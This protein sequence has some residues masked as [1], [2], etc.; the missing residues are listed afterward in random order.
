MPKRKK[1]P[2]EYTREPI[3]TA[4]LRDL[5]SRK[6]AGVVCW[7]GW[8]VPI[9][10]VLLA[11][12]GHAADGLLPVAWKEG[13]SLDEFGFVTRR[14]SGDGTGVSGRSLFCLPRALRS[15]G[16]SGLA[17]TV[18]VDQCNSHFHA[19]MARHPGKAALLQ[20]TRERDATLVS[21][22]EAGVTRE[23]AKVLFLQL[24]YGGSIASW[25]AEHGVAEDSLPSFVRQF[26]DEQAAIRAED[27][28][29][30]P[31]LLAKMKDKKRPEI[32]LQSHLNMRWEREVLDA[33]AAAV[34]GLAS[35]GSY[36]HDG[37]YL[38]NPRLDPND[39]D[40]GHAW[41]QK[42]LGRVRAQVG[43]PISIKQPPSFEDVLAELRERWPAEDW[44]TCDDC[45]VLEQ[46]ALIEEA[47][48]LEAKTSLHSLYARIVALDPRAYVDHAWSVRQLFKHRG[49]GQYWCF[50]VAAKKW[51]TE[52]ARDKLL[53]VICD[54][55]GRRVRNW[56]VSFEEEGGMQIE[57]DAASPQFMCVGLAESVEKLLRTELR[58]PGFELDGEDARRYIVFTNCA[59]DKENGNELELSPVFRSSHCTG[60]ALEGTG[61]NEAE[62]DQLSDAMMLVG[63]EDAACTD[64]ACRALDACAKFIPALA[65]LY[66]ICG[67]WERTLYL[68]KHLARALFALPYCEHLWTRG[69]GANGKDTLANLMQSLLGGYFCNLPCEALTGGREMDAP[70]QTLLAL[71]GKRFAAVREISRNAKIRSHIYKTVADPKGKIK[72]RGLYGKDEEFSPHFL[73]Y[74]AS[75]VPVDL[76]DSSGGSARRTRIVDLPFNF[77]EA[78]EAAN[79]KLR[80]AALEQQFAAWRP[81]FFYY[82]S[83]VYCRFLKDQN[84]ANVTPVPP[85]IAEAVDAEMEEPWMIKLTGF[86]RDRLVPASKPRDAS[87]AAEVRQA[88]FDYCYG[89]VPKKEVGLRLARKGFAEDSVNFYEGV[90]RTKKR[91]YRVKTDDGPQLM[92]LRVGSTGGSG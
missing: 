46:G 81:G 19:Q 36:E 4:R 64:E 77:V 13:G 42:V 43:S 54:V 15:C 21:V 8:D 9:R 50:D 80:D 24:A 14:Y 29:R 71:K 60:W 33:M 47:L 67:T 55:L 52:D 56:H 3:N 51:T 40:G 63:V 16:R 87:S 30:H 58:D 5:A 22:M 89:E 48:R 39:E 25:C 91:V 78:P 85:D 83:Q 61:V 62:E 90:K 27:A 2:L 17:N 86:V 73:L 7:P 10:T 11:Y 35:I 41:Q 44:D 88:F 26:A 79:E 57:Q 32:A 65:F 53:V 18:D 59:F 66:S 68:S 76:D 75:N 23:S 82:L 92:M 72:A 37:L 31:E 45:P 20:Y 74:L 69:P 1:Q 49:A 28:E 6:A 38:Y 70:S 84:Q 12:V 34:R